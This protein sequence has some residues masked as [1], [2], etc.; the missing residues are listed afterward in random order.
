MPVGSISSSQDTVGI[1]VV[2]YKVPVLESKEEVIENCRCIADF[3]E[4]TKMG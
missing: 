1:A 2:N 4:G 3:V